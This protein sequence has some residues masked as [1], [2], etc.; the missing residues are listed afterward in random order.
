MGVEHPKGQGCEEAKQVVYRAYQN[1]PA[2]HL[3]GL[4][5]LRNSAGDGR[6]EALGDGQGNDDGGAAGM[7][8]MGG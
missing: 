1:H 4:K 2:R 3:I 6:A 7:Q 8:D 5:D